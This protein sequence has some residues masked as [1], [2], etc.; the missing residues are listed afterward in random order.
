MEDQALRDRFEAVCARMRDA[1]RRSGRAEAEVR[2]VAV[3]KT[4]AADAV[5]D[6]ARHWAG[7]GT[8]P[9]FGENYAREGAAKR[10]Q[11]A[12]LVP[13]LDLEW[14]FIGHIQTNKAGE[15]AG[16]YN[17][18]HSLDSLRLARALQRALVAEGLAAGGLAAGGPP[19]AVLIQVNTG[20]E[21]QKSGVLPEELEPF[22]LALAEVRE[23]EIQGLMCL[24][25]NPE[26]AESSRPHFRRL[27]EL[28]ESMR[29]RSGLALPH[30]S[31]GMSHDFEAA[32][33]EGATL[34]RVGTEI[35][36]SRN[37]HPSSDK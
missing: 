17:L 8:R 4:H 29:S 16:R 28:R 19:Q 22:L 15:T 5:A 31:M 35:F 20:R 25:P 14:H 36:G 37:G 2:L 3:S 21:P 26:Q 7:R 1:A 33:E 23:L 34:I 27:R 10:A 18:I 30:L 9:A 24:P 11:V 6:L 13:G 32:V 12:R